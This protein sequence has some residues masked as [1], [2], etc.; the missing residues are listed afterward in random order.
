MSYRAAL[1]ITAVLLS[2]AALP[3][4]NAA[5][6]ESLAAL[7]LP[8]TTITSA[9]TVAA[10]AFTLP[11]GS[12][13]QRPN[14]FNAFN[15]LPV[16]CR[17]QAVIQPSSDSHIEFEVWLPISGWNGRYQGTGN[18]GFAGGINFGDLAEAVHNGYASSSTDTGHEASTG[19]AEWAL[20]HPEKIIDFGYRAIH[21]TAEKSKAVIRAFYGEG[22][23]H[24]Y[25]SSC[26]NGGR[27]ALMEAQR[28]AADYD[29]LIAGAPAANFTRM[30]AGFTWNVQS[31]EADPASYIPADRFP[32]I[33][34]AALAA[35]DAL[36]GVKDG[37]IDDPRKCHFD[38]AVL[39]CRGAESD[40]CL[41][42]PQ[43]VALK[44]IYAGP[45]NSK[46]EQVYPGY[47][48]GGESGW[49]PWF[50]GSGPGKSGQ[51]AF[52]TQGDAYMIYQNAALDYRT[53]NLDKDLKT[54][55][56]AMGARLNAIDPN[57]KALKDRGGKLILYHGWSDPALV[58]TATVN[59]YE[60]VVAKMGQKETADF[61]RLY[62]VPGMSHC[63]G[64]PGPDSF[65]AYP[66]RGADPDFS[67]FAALEG[68]VE[69]GVAPDKIIATKYKTDGNPASGVVR[70]RPLCPYPQVAKYTGSGSTDEAASFVCKAPDAK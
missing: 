32:A 62:M 38:P 53:V 37:V 2:T 69:K 4:A 33:E 55:E 18:G 56:D 64:G 31:V 25:F 23:Q 39:L 45:R 68:W 47:Q 16:F 5:T 14:P 66:E 12:Q 20:G 61:V 24:S 48:P 9:Q 40:G 3:S 11:A 10:G 28:Y 35:C 51:Y 63:D 29:G 27:Q 19:N 34:K 1:L 57:L 15:M 58:P 43:V 26:S 6:C 41:T 46:G 44:K 42:Q 7:K 22:P 50:A 67:M 30:A 8:N 36:D 60:N 49:V 65:G 17:V 54:S 52:T 59:Y 13:P 70:T 21:E